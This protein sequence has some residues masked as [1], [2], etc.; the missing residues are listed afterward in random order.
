[1]MFSICLL[2]MQA[3]SA[4]A[5]A[6]SIESS[7]D[8][9]VTITV[10]EG[11][12]VFVQTLDKSG[13]KIERTALVTTAMLEQLLE[14]TKVSMRE[15]MQ[16]ALQEA[17]DAVD[18]TLDAVASNFT[19]IGKEFAI[20]SGDMKSS[21]ETVLNLATDAIQA[22]A[23]DL[24]RA[25]DDLSSV[26]SNANVCMGSLA[27]SFGGL[28]DS[29][30]DS[31]KPKQCADLSSIPAGTVHGTNRQVGATRGFRCNDGAVMVGKAHSFCGSDL[32]W[33]PAPP[34][35]EA[36]IDCAV[37]IDNAINDVYV[38]GKQVKVTCTPQRYTYWG[39]TQCAFSFPSSAKT[40]AIAGYDRENGCQGGG[41]LLSCGSAQQTNLWTA[42]TSRSGT[43]DNA[44]NKWKAIGSER[45]TT[46]TG[47]AWAQPDF[48]DSKWPK[49]V[50]AQ[51]R[52][53]TVRCAKKT[54][55]GRKFQDACSQQREGPT[56]F[57]PTEECIDNEDSNI[58]P[59]I[60]ADESKAVNS[61]GGKPT[62]WW[63]RYAL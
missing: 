6:P 56:L 44:A 51:L 1:V 49:A 34:K 19:N 5:V 45:E 43:K 42:V 20:A 32:Q 50:Q 17:T 59:M 27:H 53:D 21:T 40:L 62:Y 39:Q 58:I 10:A 54:S 26:S 47:S 31:D 63:F 41:M 12:S 52:G 8:G 60:C 22:V 35:C 38:D 37:F 61:A 57:C 48:D 9:S 3:L 14:D 24:D 15:E 7:A 30:P 55:D 18:V 25:I 11:T 23:D 46:I 29:C 36:K 2:L 13:R 28:F 33:S 16:V 4:V